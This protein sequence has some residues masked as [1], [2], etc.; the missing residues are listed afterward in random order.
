MGDTNQYTSILWTKNH[1]RLN[2]Y[3]IKLL[4]IITRSFLYL[5]ECFPT[6]KQ[7]W[8]T[9]SVYFACNSLQKTDISVMCSFLKDI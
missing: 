5:L 9:F 7:L 6:N 8:G 4:K 3:D 2:D 1:L